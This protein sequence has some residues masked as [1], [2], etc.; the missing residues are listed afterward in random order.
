MPAIVPT[1]GGSD[2]Q[3]TV[4]VQAPGVPQARIQPMGPEVSSAGIHEAAAGIG[5][6]VTE[7]ASHLEMHM[8]MQEKLA[9]QQRDY[10]TIEQY[11]MAMQ[12]KLANPENG[13]LIR[14]QG[15]NAPKALAEFDTLTRGVPSKPGEPGSPALRD[16][17][18][19]GASQYDRTRLEK[20]FDSIDSLNRGKLISHVLTQKEAA[21]T[22]IRNAA[23]DSQKN[24]AAL[25]TP[26]NVKD[27]D[28]GAYVPAIKL[29]EKQMRDTITN[30]ISFKLA[31]HPKPEIDKIVQDHIDEIAKEAVGANV[32]KNWQDAQK[33]L[34][35]SSASPSAKLGL[36][37]TINGARTDQYTETLTNEVIRNPAM[38]TPEGQID[39]TKAQDYVLK[40]ITAQ[41]KSGNPLPPGHQDAM[42]SKVQSQIAIQNKAVS[43]RQQLVMNKVSN[44][45]WAAQ[46]HGMDPK[47]AYEKFIKQGKFDNAIE[48]GKAEDVFTK[49]FEK[50]PSA[51][52]T[53]WSHMS[54][55]QKSAISEIT[56]SKDF[57]DKFP[58]TQDQKNFEGVLKQKIIEG[59][60]QSPDAINKLYQDQLKT[61]PTGAAR[62]AGFGRQERQ[63]YKVDQSLQQNQPVVKA[64]GGLDAASK[65]ARDLGG[66]DKLAPDTPASKAVLLLKQNGF[67][68]SAKNVFEFIKN[69]PDMVK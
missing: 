52:D 26:L 68:V 64:V 43:Q 65:L 35:A 16:K 58:Y 30:D 56:N 2:N 18:M 33:V 46:Q 62:F 60:L 48:R 38:R 5:K 51:L 37:H 4:G 32:S 11:K 21:D 25:I 23:I 15:V 59:R 69:N 49:V 67:K 53:V 54:E 41:E 47:E 39:E 10:A 24:S 50:D 29:A 12:D 22:A 66:P 63:Q 9:A 13:I 6:E 7:I 3:P 17:L 20:A 44:D 36:Q 57:R 31:G 27:P 55:A 61:V 8:V 28:S 45:I 40:Q 34:D 1:Y 14:N 19:G 42:M